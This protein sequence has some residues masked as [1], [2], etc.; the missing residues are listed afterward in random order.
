MSVY[1]NPADESRAPE[2][3]KNSAQWLKVERL[4]YIHADL[5]KEMRTHLHDLALSD[6]R[7][8]E[9]W[10]GAVPEELEK[11]TGNWDRDIIAPTSGLSDLMYKSVGIRDARHS[12]QLGLSMWR[13]SWITFIFLPLTFTVGFFGMNV[14]SF[15]DNPPIKWWFVVSIPVLALVLILWYGVKHSL[16]K[17]R[18]NP[19]RRGVYEALYHE[20]ATRHAQ[21][22]S[23]SGPRKGV[24]MVGWWNSIKWR[25]VTSWFG[26]EKV[27]PLGGYDPA[28]QEFGAWSRMKQYL[29]RRWLDELP[30]M[31]VSAL[32]TTTNEISEVSFD[33]DLGAVGELL[34]IA[35]PV[36]IAEL[37][38][39][40]ASRLQKRIPVERLRS[41]SPTR[42]DAGSAGRP[43]SAA[44]SEKVM[45]E[46]KG[47]SEDERSGD[48]G[49]GR[50]VD[51][52]VV[53]RDRVVKEGGGRLDVPGREM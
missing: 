24:V 13:L 29:V 9:P 42:S 28:T 46:E 40:A 37:D 34:S 32:P 23:R 11:L 38:P 12:L 49:G 41:L 16:S 26:E 20:L 47:A 7:D 36:A 1:E 48:E 18:Q 27:K 8:D 30:V 3:W 33:K 45:V 22:W 53:G 21:L 19:L 15:V 14:D 31:T 4:L 10:L 51:G 44:G 39:T 43:T 2:L 25:L 6:S 35:T 50:K 5:V 52:K 17:Q